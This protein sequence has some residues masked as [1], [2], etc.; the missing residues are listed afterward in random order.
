MYYSETLLWSNSSEKS[1]YAVTYCYL[2]TLNPLY[3][4]TTKLKGLHSKSCRYSAIPYT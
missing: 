4:T 3:S 2:L 1:M